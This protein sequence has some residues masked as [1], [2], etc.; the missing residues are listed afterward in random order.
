MD[1]VLQQRAPAPGEAALRDLLAP[2]GISINGTRPWDLRIRDPRCFRRILADGSLGLGETYVEGWWEAEAVDELICRLLSSGLDHPLPSQP[3]L[4]WE[5]LKSRFINPQGLRR[6]RRVTETHYDLGNVFYQRMLDPWMQYT[7][8]YWKN[9]SDLATAQEAKLELVCRKL[10]LRAGD[11]IL[12]L[13]GGWGGFAR[14]AA[15]R[16]G[17]RVTLYNLSKEQVAYA[18]ERCAGLPV[19]VHHAD[20]RSAA[21]TFDKVVSIGLCE[22]VGARNYPAFFALQQ[23]CLKPDGLMLLHT[24]GCNRTKITTDP[25]IQ[26]YV[27]P[28]GQ[29]PSLRQLLTAAEGRF[30]LEDLHNIGADYDPTLMAWHHNF[31][32]HWPEFRDRYG[33]RFHRL[34]RYYLL[35]CAGAFRARS[36]HLWQMV[37]SPNG[38]AGGY[39]AVR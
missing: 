25:W 9:A 6:S 7:C 18:R 27:F 3:R 38:I 21:G 13:G 4:L 33:D 28:G 2:A 20:Y 17:C 19:E 5:W 39:T 32:R 14:Y 31:E 35:S 22:H 10:G 15:E 37:F 26:R 29:L 16:F 34:W 24:I 30:V 1:T 11:H 8:A 23:R 12:E 36:I